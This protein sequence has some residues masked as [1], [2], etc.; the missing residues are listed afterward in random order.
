MQKPIKPQR[1]GS[2]EELTADL[3]AD[4]EFHKTEY[5]K[6]AGHGEWLVSWNEVDS[7]PRISNLQQMGNYV[8]KYLEPN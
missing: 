2:V 6:S 7:A 1:N 5:Q 4:M 3:C 8:N